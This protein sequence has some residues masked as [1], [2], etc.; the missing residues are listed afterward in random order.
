MQIA[1]CGRRRRHFT[2]ITLLSWSLGTARRRLPSLTAAS[3]GATLDRNGLRPARYLVTHDG[4]V[5]LGSEAGVLPVKPEEVKFKGRL[6]PGRMLLVDTVEGRIIP[7]EE[8]KERLSSRKPYGEWLK[9]NQIT[10][11]SLPEPPRVYESDL[12]KHRDAATR[13][14]LYRRRS[15]GPDAAH[16]GEGRRAH[17]FHGHRHAA[18]LSFRQAT[19]LVPLLQA[20]VC[21]GNQ[22]GHRSHS[23]GAGDVADQLHRE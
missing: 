11:D 17:R 18:G 12:D 20:V 2:N 13:L 16:G 6:Q 15:A 4:L 7:D 8:M 1:P 9:D 21:A 5:I 19:A 22:S 3:I 10:L 14:R 23:R